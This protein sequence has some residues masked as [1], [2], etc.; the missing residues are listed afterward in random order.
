MQYQVPSGMTMQ[1]FKATPDFQAQ[2]KAANAA[3]AA[4]AWG[5]PQ[6]GS[7]QPKQQQSQGTS[8]NPQ[9]NAPNMSAWSG[10]QQQQ[11]GF[12]GFPQVPAFQFRGTDFMGNQFNDS[13]TCLR[14][15]C[16]CRR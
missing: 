7:A 5:G 2:S 9:G 10:G 13:A 14:R 6:P 8:Y 3:Y 15:T 1:Q 16:P 4:G 12:S 11:G